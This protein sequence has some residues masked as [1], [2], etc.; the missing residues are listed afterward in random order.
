MLTGTG[1]VQNIGKKEK[2]KKKS[3]G[4]IASGLAGGLVGGLTGATTSPTD[5]DKDLFRDVA[6]VSRPGSTMQKYRGFA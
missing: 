3:G 6:P 5:P 4:I 1:G 2:D